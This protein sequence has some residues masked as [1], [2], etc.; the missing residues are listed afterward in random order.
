[1]T[2]EQL[3]AFNRTKEANPNPL[4]EKNADG[5]F[6][7]SFD[8][9]NTNSDVVQ[10]YAEC[11][12]SLQAKKDQANQAAVQ[13]GQQPQGEEESNSIAGALDDPNTKK[14]FAIMN[15]FE[16]K[17]QCSGICVTGLFYATQQVSAGRPREPCL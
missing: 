6:Y 12:E 13:A 5:L 10:T 17:Y 7:L 11:L 8:D 4:A 14:A 16:Q 9:A 3:A 1:M 2:A 15:Y